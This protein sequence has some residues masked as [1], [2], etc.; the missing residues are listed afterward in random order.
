MARLEDFGTLMMPEESAEPILARPVRNA[1]LEWLTEVWAADELVKVGLKP[2]KRAMF[3]GAPGTGKTTLAHHLAARLGLP[4]LA[5]RP[6]RIISSYLG[7]TGKKLGSVFDAANDPN[8]PIVLFIDE[9]DSIGLKRK[10]A[11]NG[12]EDERNSSTNT[13]LQAIDRHGGFL[14]AATNF[15]D[16]IDSAV[17]RRFDLQITIEL[18]GQFERE[19]IVERY[20]APYVLPP[21]GLT[22]LAKAMSSA[23]PDL[24]RTFCEGIKRQVIIGP[25]VGWDMER[26][27]VFSRLL[28]TIQPHPDLGRPPLWVN[29][30]KNAAVDLIPWP[31]PMAE[32]KTGGAK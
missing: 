16:T 14:I 30:A 3:S 2:R 5:V 12:A 10:N 11:S 15:A 28:T 27:A 7:E 8:N 6:D 17:W 31:I 21:E 24:M 23:S 32:P 19:R 13:L 1:L 29:G 26:E 9:F 18:P 22:A 4:M 25:K 20:L